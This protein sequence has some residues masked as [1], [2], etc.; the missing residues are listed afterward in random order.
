MRRSAIGWC[1]GNG[2]PSI[3]FDV[4]SKEMPE[5]CLSRVKD[6][7]SATDTSVKGSS[8]SNYSFFTG[9]ILALASKSKLRVPESCKRWYWR[10]QSQR[11]SVRCQEFRVHA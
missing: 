10:S 3:V 6:I 2:K 11:C 9:P 1:S 8:N 5:Q 7:D 4:T